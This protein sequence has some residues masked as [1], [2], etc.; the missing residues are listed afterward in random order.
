MP[1][2]LLQNR[3]PCWVHIA[4]LLIYAPEMGKPKPTHS[5]TASCWA[6]N[7]ALK[8]RGALLI[9]L[10]RGMAWRASKAGRNGRPTVF[11]GVTDWKTVQV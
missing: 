10:D 6:C 9:R 7:A 8:R 1:S 11:S 4:N 3:H 5:R 2:T